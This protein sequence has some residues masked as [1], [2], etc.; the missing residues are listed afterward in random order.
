MSDLS[1]LIFFHNLEPD[2]C[3]RLGKMLWS[4]ASLTSPLLVLAAA[5]ASLGRDKA[6]L[7]MHLALSQE[8]SVFE[9]R[10]RDIGCYG[11]RRKDTLDFW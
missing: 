10:K 4:V 1:W 11:Q 9:V 3:A 7:L 8:S 2:R 5:P 6:L